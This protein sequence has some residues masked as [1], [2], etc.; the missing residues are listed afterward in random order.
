MNSAGRWA[1]LS[2]RFYLTSK[3][4]TG[5]GSAVVNMRLRA[6][7]LIEL[8][9][10]V[11]II[12]I[13]A[14]IAVPNFLEAQTRAKV[15][16]VMADMRTMNTAIESYRIDHNKVPIRNDH[17]N[18]DSPKRYIPDGN[19]KIYDPANPAA[20]VGLHV[21]TTPIAYLGSLPEDVFNV[22][23]RSLML[24]QEP[25]VSMSLDY[26]DILQ[27]QAFRMALNPGQ[28]L[29][30]RGYAL[31][32]VGPDKFI[33]GLNSARPGYP[34]P[35]PSWVLNSMRWMYDPSNGTTSAGNVYHFSD[36]LGQTDI[37]PVF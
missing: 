12:A 29:S 10:V 9:I 24:D 31:L 32:S 5:N 35:Q 34:M 17:W 11:A 26:W 15:A 4:R 33:G 13:L 18:D 37:Y 7:T 30:Q 28:K 3:I 23:L 14:A 22:P 27:L 21:I 8:L 2:V 20:S 6:F 36:G 16:R 19:T 25:G 1:I